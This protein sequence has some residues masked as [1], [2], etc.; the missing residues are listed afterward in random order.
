MTQFRPIKYENK[1]KI[2]DILRESFYF[3]NYSSSELV[4]E[5]MFVWN[6]DH[7][8]EILWIED[9]IAIIRSLEKENEWIF[10]PPICRSKDEFNLGLNYIR[11]NFP[12]ALVTGL[13][14]KMIEASKNQG[15]LFL[16]DD[17]YSEYIY[18]P[19]ELADMSGGKF[20][21]K[22]NLVAQF[23]KKYKYDLLSYEDIHFDKV[24]SF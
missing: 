15:C 11:D 17:Y 23:K 21:R 20:S 6:Y 16:Y 14:K 1:S 5:N 4:F 19:K 8:I 22:R 3:C 2:N 12:E 9:K 24:L 13:S 10:F 18:D 7:Q